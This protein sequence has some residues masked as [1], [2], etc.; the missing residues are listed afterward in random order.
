MTYIVFGFL[1]PSL[2]AV[3]GGICPQGTKVP[4]AELAAALRVV[5]PGKT[6]RV[7]IGA[8]HQL[9][10][11]QASDGGV[12]YWAISDRE[13]ALMLFVMPTGEPGAQL[14][15]STLLRSA[16]SPLPRGTSGGV[17]TAASF[18]PGPDGEPVRTYRDVVCPSVTPR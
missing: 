15:A 2:L 13:G 12:D 9:E 6:Q 10:T 8:C 4:E 18:E 17:L 14:K 11:R 3:D 5:A 7:M 16:G 1:L